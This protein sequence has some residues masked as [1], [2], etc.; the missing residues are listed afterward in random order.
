MVFCLLKESDEQDKTKERKLSVTFIF[1]W[2]LVFI[3]GTSC[4]CY[5]GFA[6]TTMVGSCI[7]VF[8][9][10]GQGGSYVY[11]LTQNAAPSN[12]SLNKKKE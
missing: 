3:L 2:M 4:V 6:R 10:F 5:L 7:I 8:I 1:A 9:S 12:G 11:L